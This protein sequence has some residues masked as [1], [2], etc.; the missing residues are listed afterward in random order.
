MRWSLA[1]FLILSGPGHVPG[2]HAQGNGATVAARFAAPAGAARTT[3]EP[4]SFAHYLRQLPLR[5]PG[6]AVHLFDGRPKARQDVHAAVIDMSVGG[7]DLQQ[8][9]DA[10]IRLHAEHLF[11]QGRHADI[12]YRFTNGFPAEWERWREGQRIRVE[13]NTCRWSRTATPDS[14]HA[15]LLNY[16][17]TVFSYAG[18]LSLATELVPAA[19]RPPQSGDVFIQ[20]GSPGHAVIVVDVARS[21]DGRTYLMLA[22]SYM[23]A[24]EIHILRGPVADVWYEV[25]ATDVLRTPEWTFNWSDRKRWP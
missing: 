18:T 6:S 8:C 25:G 16:L 13:G 5:P 19:H 10:V 7:K 14:S 23:P 1:A 21:A 22:Q 3:A 15:Q 20:G 12:H 24:Q 4:G 11:A 2:L 9:A 17:N